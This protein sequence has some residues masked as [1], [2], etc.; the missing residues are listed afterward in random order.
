MPKTEPTGAEAQAKAG[1]AAI[2]ARVEANAAKRSTQFVLSIFDGKGN[3]QAKRFAN[4][5]EMATYVL[6]ME[7]KYGKT[8]KSFKQD[9]KYL[10]KEQ[11][12]LLNLE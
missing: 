8:I 1:L 6:E 12:Y 7:D 2:Q 3:H 10:G 9:T 4:L 5:D 11:K